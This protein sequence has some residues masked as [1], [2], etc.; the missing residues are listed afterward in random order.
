MDLRGNGVVLPNSALL[1]PFFSSPAAGAAGG[2]TSPGSSSLTA[3]VKTTE[4]VQDAIVYH[5]LVRTRSTP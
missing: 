4:W 2:T 3:P 1:I 5:V